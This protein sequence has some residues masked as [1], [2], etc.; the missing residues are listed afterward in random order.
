MHNHTGATKPRTPSRRTRRGLRQL[1]LPLRRPARA[2][3]CRPSRSTPPPGATSPRPLDS[4]ARID[5]TVHLRSVSGQALADVLVG[6]R[7]DSGGGH[8]DTSLRRTTE[9]NGLGALDAG[10]GSRLVPNV[11]PS[12]PSADRPVSRD[13]P[14][15]HPA[16]RLSR[17]ARQRH[18]GTA[19]PARDPSTGVGRMEPARHHFQRHGAGANHRDCRYGERPGREGRGGFSQPGPRRLGTF[20]IRVEAAGATPAVSQPFDIVP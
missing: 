5:P 14:W 20:R 3:V 1:H 19:A 13:G 10:T 9:W 4:V 6:R 11:L 16:P 2:R 12:R 17:R 15:T 8:V 18:V 7:V